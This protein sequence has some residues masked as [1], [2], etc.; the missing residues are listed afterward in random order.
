MAL[1]AGTTSRFNS[2]CGFLGPG[3][4]QHRALCGCRAGGASRLRAQGMRCLGC[5]RPCSLPPCGRQGAMAG[6]ISPTG[7]CVSDVL[8]ARDHPRALRV[9]QAQN[10]A[11]EQTSAGWRAACGTKQAMQPGC[12]AAPRGAILST[13]ALF[14][15]PLPVGRGAFKLRNAPRKAQPRPPRAPEGEPGRHGAAARP[16][17][18]PSALLTATGRPLPGEPRLGRG[19]EPR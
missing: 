3:G 16:F 5:L 11:E 12:C 15:D 2:C 14:G 18:S 17:P 7:G 8:G 9:Q 19:A 6:Q 4:Q 10:T 13:A 1:P